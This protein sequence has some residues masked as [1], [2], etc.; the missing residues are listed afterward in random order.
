VIQSL[1]LSWGRF[2]LAYRKSILLVLAAITLLTAAQFPRIRFDNSPQ[3]WFVEGD[4]TLANHR[5]LLDTFGSDELVVVGIE[6]PDVFAPDVLEKI[7][8]AT[9]AIEKAPHVEKVF[10]LTSIESIIGKDDLLEVGDL[11]EFPLDPATLPAIRERALANQMYVGNVVSRDG[12]FTAIVARLPHHPDEIDYK[13]ES[14]GAI[15]EILEREIGPDYYLSGGPPLDEQF[16][17][18][19]TADSA[20]TLYLM[21]GFLATVLWLLTRSLWGIVLPLVTV[22]LATIWT[23]GSMVLFGARVN[24]IT[25]I[26]PPLLLAVGVADAMHVVVDYQNRFRVGDDKRTALA[27]VFGELT[28]PLFL[29]GLTTAIGMSSLGVSRVLAIREFGIFAALGVS[30]AF[31]LTVTLVP[32]LLSYLPPPRRVVPRPGK[33]FFSTRMLDALHRFTMRRGRAIVAVSLALLAVAVFF[34]TRVR[35]ESAFLQVFKKSARV[36]VDTEKIQES[37]GGA[38]TMDVLIDAGREDGVKDPDVLAAI[39]AL[40]DFLKAQPHVSSTQSVTAYFKDIR[41]AFFGNDQREYRLPETREEAAQY[42]LLYEMDAPDGDLK[43]L[44]TFDYR[45][46][47]VTARIDLESSNSAATLVAATTE[48]IRTEFPA[49]MRGTVTGLSVMYAVMEEY[50]RDSLVQGFSGALLCIFLV[51]CV[52]MRSVILGAIVML[53][54]SMPIMI[55]LGIMGAFGI[56]LDSMTAMV[57]SVAIGLADDDSIHF[58][59]RVRLKLDAGSDVVTALREAIVE[60]GRA[61]VF[62][63]LSLSAGFLVMLT[64]SFVGAIYFGL[65]TTLTIVIALLAD[66]I[67]LPVMLRWYDVHRRRPQPV[68]VP[69][70]QALQE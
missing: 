19:S 29:T 30:V 21:L 47:R 63:G 23:I 55:T 22:S 32:I 53:A 12:R 36:R 65:L 15:R 61:L 60:V 49:G 18:V 16:L 41:R 9:R 28:W 14:V 17:L 26:L 48:Y 45:E 68:P 52:Q 3:T 1:S 25:T 56:R 31:L 51:F 70:Q 33:Q 24:I 2:C 20:R 5:L 54:N 34:S 37:L 13:V 64:S 39:A 50:I 69:A 46:T 4:P 8:R 40:E 11:I 6:A 38:I 43:E 10:S 58:V 67:L 59:S 62:S 57:A 7:D 35:A 42:L 66:L 27:A 44:M